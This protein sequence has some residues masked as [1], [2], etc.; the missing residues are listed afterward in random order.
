[1]FVHIRFIC[2]SIVL[3]WIG[4]RPLVPLRVAARL[5]LRL[6]ALLLIAAWIPALAILCTLAH[7]GLRWTTELIQSIVQNILLT[8]RLDCLLRHA[9]LALV[10]TAEVSVGETRLLLHTLKLATCFFVPYALHE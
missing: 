2:A 7:F 9:N 8:V 10:G 3:V 5:R 4:T 6:S 1:M